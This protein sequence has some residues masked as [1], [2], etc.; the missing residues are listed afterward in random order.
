MPKRPYFAPAFTRCLS[1]DSVPSGPGAIAECM[2]R[3]AHPG[4]PT[5]NTPSAEH[6]RSESAREPL[7][8]ANAGPTSTTATP[9]STLRAVFVPNR[10]NLFE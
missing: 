1:P 2:G 8:G 4:V 6:K 5:T 7:Q 3:A 10:A 9:N